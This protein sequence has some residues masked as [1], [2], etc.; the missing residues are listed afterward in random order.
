MNVID[1]IYDSKGHRYVVETP[2]CFHC[3]KTGIIE[4]EAQSMF[5]YRQGWLIQDAFTD[6][7]SDLREQM[8]SGSHPECFEAMFKE[9]E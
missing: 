9:E 7:S 8:I 5:Y 1:E 2:T 4:V 6:I 3:G